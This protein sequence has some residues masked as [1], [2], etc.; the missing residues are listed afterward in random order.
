MAYGQAHAQD[1]VGELVGE[2]IEELALRDTVAEVGLA[3]DVGIAGARLSSSQ[4]QKLALSRAILKRPDILIMFESTA[5]LD[6][7]SQARIMDGLLEEFQGRSV[8]WAVHRPE[9]AERFDTM[10][11]M[12]QGRVIEEGS[13]AELSAQE[14]LFAR[15]VSRQST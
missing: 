12:R 5:S 6:S 1:R 14:G 10:L 3:Y 2:V 15:L 13:F 8:I 4:R 9:M 11:V 7:N